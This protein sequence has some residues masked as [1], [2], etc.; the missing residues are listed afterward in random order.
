MKGGNREEGGEKLSQSSQTVG[1]VCICS[2]EGFRVVPKQSGGLWEIRRDPLTTHPLSLLRLLHLCP[3]RMYIPRTLGGPA[4]TM[5]L[6]ASR[7]RRLH[8]G[9]PEGTISKRSQSELF[10]FMD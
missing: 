2:G 3:V 7:T 1:E 6:C 4:G 5:G 10:H 8:A 9:I